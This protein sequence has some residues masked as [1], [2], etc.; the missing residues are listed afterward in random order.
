MKNNVELGGVTVMTDE[1]I[2]EFVLMSFEDIER[3]RA[4]WQ[5]Y[6]SR[7]FADLIDAQPME[8]ILDVAA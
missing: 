4:A 6:A 1:E 2:D 3:L 5:R 8:D 7:P